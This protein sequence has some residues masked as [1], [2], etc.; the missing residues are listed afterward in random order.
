[1]AGIASHLLEFPPEGQL[2]PEQYNS[3]IKSFV[4][5]LFKTDVSKVLKA[6]GQQDF[7]QILN[8]G[9]NSISYLFILALRYRQF[10]NA[11]SQTQTE[12]RTLLLQA[13]NFMQQFDPIQIRY[14][15]TILRDVVEQ[16]L[17]LASHLQAVSSTPVLVSLW[18]R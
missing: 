13:L 1:M 17:T 7:L 16:A 18:T 4:D 8:P 6:D 2:S 9:V 10:N 15:G 14:V 11:K 3:S 12:A 5:S